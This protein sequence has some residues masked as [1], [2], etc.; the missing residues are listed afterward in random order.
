MIPVL[1]VNIHADSQCEGDDRVGGLKEEGGFRDM[2][3]G[4]CVY[5]RMLA[6]VIRLV[7]SV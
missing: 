5:L 4:S 7:Y 3:M 6:M 2:Y 1:E